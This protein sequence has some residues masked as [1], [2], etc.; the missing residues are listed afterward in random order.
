M[1]A[2]DSTMNMTNQIGSVRWMAPEVLLYDERCSYAADV[3]SFGCTCLEVSDLVN[4]HLI[5]LM[6]IRIDFLRLSLVN[7]RSR[8][9]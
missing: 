7:I 4:R 1:D 9:S 6:L 2:G 8:S 3:Y 5:V